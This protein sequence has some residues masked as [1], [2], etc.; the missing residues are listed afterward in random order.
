MFDRGQVKRLSCGVGFETFQDAL[1]AC[2]ANVLAY[3]I[4]DFTVHGNHFMPHAGCRG[5]LRSAYV[6]GTVGITL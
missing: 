1:G 4:P 2:M 6:D 3:N 5:S